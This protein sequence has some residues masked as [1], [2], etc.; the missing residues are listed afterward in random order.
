MDAPAAAAA[1]VAR[2]RATTHREKD[3]PSRAKEP[4]L[5]A[6]EAPNR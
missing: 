2:E 5:Q 3:R 1:S 4:D 6:F